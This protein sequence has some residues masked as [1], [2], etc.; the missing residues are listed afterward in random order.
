MDTPMTMKGMCESCMMPFKK[1]P[2]GTARESEKYCSYCFADGKLCYEGTDIKEFK[3]VMIEQ[4]TSRGT[5]PLKA[6]F[7]AYM[8]GFAPR[9]KH[10]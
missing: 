10:K 9:W 4:M 6:T 7:F 3:R 8:A 5:R 2:K 1:D